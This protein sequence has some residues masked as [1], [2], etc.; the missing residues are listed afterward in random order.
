M[1]T[2]NTGH[3][4]NLGRSKKYGLS[5]LLFREYLDRVRTK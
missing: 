5:P 1:K 3:F 4:S 2:K